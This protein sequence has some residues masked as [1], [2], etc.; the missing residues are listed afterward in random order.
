MR[1]LPKEIRLNAT[2]LLQHGCSTCEVSKLLV[3]LNLH[4]LGFVESVFLVWNLQEEGAPRSITPTQ[5]Q[6]CVRAIT[7]DGVDKCCRREEC[8]E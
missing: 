2:T 7:V 8:F 1:A 4:A 3:F 6:G 5:Q